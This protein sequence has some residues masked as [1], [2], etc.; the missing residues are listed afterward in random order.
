MTK[1]SRGPSGRR[2][3]SAVGA[4]KSRGI[5]GCGVVGDLP[6]SGPGRVGVLSCARHAR[7]TR[8]RPL[9]ARA[10]R[11]AGAPS[12]PSLPDR[13]V[14]RARRVANRLGE[15]GEPRL[16]DG[17]ARLVELGEGAYGDV[18]LRGELEG[19]T[20]GA[21]FGTADQ[22]AGSAPRLAV[23]AGGVGELDVIAEHL[24]IGV[25]ELVEVVGGKP[26][27]GALRWVVRRAMVTAVVSA[28]SK[29]KVTFSS[30]SR[31]YVRAR[32]RADR[33]PILPSGW[34]ERLTTGTAVV[35]TR[36]S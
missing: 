35:A 19:L 32:D 27:P 9:R 28:R 25:D 5:H 26:A 12:S 34:D 33:R 13:P 22:V 15:A 29:R 14:P 10:S 24:E 2:A 17:G 8:A 31:R 16:G 7:A 6:Q 1:T 11:P 36:I 18:A 21:L 20:A 30:T 3:N 23:G 4:A